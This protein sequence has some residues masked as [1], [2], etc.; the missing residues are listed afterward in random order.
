MIKVYIAA[1][2]TEIEFTSKLEV[3]HDCSGHG[4]V[5]REGMRNHAYSAEEFAEF[6]DEQANEYFSHGGR[7]DVTCPTC[8]GKNVIPVVDRN[9][10]NPKHIAM[11]DKQH[12]KDAR[13][14]QEDAYERMYC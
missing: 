11:L 9:N 2:N 4:T 10:N 8:N 5:L 1:L 6:D 14:R 7:Y 12:A 13:D 3:C